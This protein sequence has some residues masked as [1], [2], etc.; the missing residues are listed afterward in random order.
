MTD[1]KETSFPVAEHEAHANDGACSLADAPGVTG[2]S[3]VTIGEDPRRRDNMVTV[4]SSRVRPRADQPYFSY[5][6]T[7]GVG[8][9]IRKFSRPTSE[10]E[11]TWA[12]QDADE[13]GLLF[14]M[15]GGGSNTVAGDGFFNGL[16]LQDARQEITV[17]SDS[18]C[19]GVT[20]TATAGMPWDDFVAEAVANEWMGVEALSGIPGTVG[21]AP[22]QNIGAYGQEVAETIASVRVWD[23][24]TCRV[25]QLALADLELEYRNSIL[26]RSLTDPEVGGGRVWGPTGRWVVLSVTFQ[27][28][29]ASLSSPIRYGQLASALGVNVGDRVESRQVRDAV[30]DIRRSKGMVLDDEDRDTWSSGSFFT[31]PIVGAE[32]AARLPADAPRFPVER[33]AQASGIQGRAPVLEGVVK[34]SA[35]WLIQHAGFGPG[36]RLSAD[37]HAALSSRHCLA[38]TN[39]GEATGTEIRVLSDTIRDGVRK[40]FGVEIYPEPV[41][42]D[43]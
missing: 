25:R 12:I 20:V 11:L 40:Q 38:I 42:L 19:G 1:N 4:P 3:G 31:N 22:V 16:V 17:E 8:G 5:L 27:F 32:D 37:A 33:R 24:A 35:A 9:L 7:M 6:T 15:L 43:N 2:S 13:R 14:F 34:V 10:D 23:R 21:A 36:F 29:H 28:R 39:R 41:L 18:A 30:L 26:K